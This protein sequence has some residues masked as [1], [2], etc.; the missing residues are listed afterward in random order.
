LTDAVALLA[1]DREGYVPLPA[2][3]LAAQRAGASVMPIKKALFTKGTVDAYI[4]AVLELWRV[5]V[6]YSNSNIKNLCGIAVRGFLKQRGRQQ[7]K[8]NCETY[9]DYGGDGI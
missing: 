8:L 3:E 1:N 7:G 4:V 9:K 2:L 5:Q 6:A